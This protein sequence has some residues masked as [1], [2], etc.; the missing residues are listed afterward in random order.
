[1]SL[2]VATFR[3]VCQL[4]KVTRSRTLCFNLVRT[5]SKYTHATTPPDTKFEKA[6][7]DVYGTIEDQ[8]TAKHFIFALKKEERTLLYEELRKFHE[9]HKLNEGQ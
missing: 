8:G 4:C 7:R 6:Y 2:S 1:M 3:R 5:T 9:D